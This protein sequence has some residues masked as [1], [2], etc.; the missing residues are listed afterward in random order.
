M[1]VYGV[2]HSSFWIRC[3]QS[4]QNHAAAGENDVSYVMKQEDEDDDKITV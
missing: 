2:H 4:K 3:T 1:Y